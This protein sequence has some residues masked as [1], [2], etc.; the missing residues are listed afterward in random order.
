MSHDFI[1]IGKNSNMNDDEKYLFDLTG[2][3]VVRGVLDQKEIDEEFKKNIPLSK[4]LKKKIKQPQPTRKGKYLTAREKR[5]LGLSK[6]DKDGLKFE[7][8][9]KLHYLWLDYMREIIDF[10]K[11]EGSETAIDSG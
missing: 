1:I 5:D 7:T 2:Y 8:F 6:L 4:Q 3:I 10:G 11:I 9:K